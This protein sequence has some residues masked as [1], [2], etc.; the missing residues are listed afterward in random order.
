MPLYLIVPCAKVEHEIAGFQ[1]WRRDLLGMRYLGVL[2][3]S[4]MLERDG[5]GCDEIIREEEQR[6]HIIIS[7]LTIYSALTRG[8]LFFWGKTIP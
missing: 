7:G 5:A 1:E 6:N 2:V 3:C 4:M 8:N